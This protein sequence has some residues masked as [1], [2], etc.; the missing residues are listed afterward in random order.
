MS[1][2]GEPSSTRRVT[3]ASSRALSDDAASAGGESVATTRRG[4]TRR[5]ATPAKES[6]GKVPKVTNKPSHAYGAEGKKAYAQQMSATYALNEATNPITSAVHGADAPQL[7]GASDADR[8]PILAEEGE[9]STHVINPRNP[10][11][12]SVEDV[13]VVE[14]TSRF[15]AFGNFFE[16]MTLWAP[17]VFRFGQQNTEVNIDVDA[18]DFWQQ[19]AEEENRRREEAETRAKTTRMCL[20]TLK[21]LV[22]LALCAILADLYVGPLFGPKYDF[23]RNR[24]QLQKR[25]GHTAVQQGNN[26]TR[27]LDK[28]EQIIQN[29]APNSRFP[30]VTIKHHINWFA[31]SNGAVVDPYLSSPVDYN[32]KGIKKHTWYSRL[33]SIGGQCEPASY[34]QGQALLPWT[35][36]GERW[37]APPSR[38]KLQLTVQIA[39]PVAPTKL[40]LEH[41]P[42]DASLRIG[43]APKE[44]ELWVEVPDEDVHA[45]VSDAIG[46]MEPHLFADSSPQQ[47]RELDQKQALPSTFVPVGRWIYNIYAHDHVQTFQITMPLQEL[48]VRATRFAVRVNSNW[49]DY[50]H[51]CIYRARLHGHDQSGL[52]EKLEEGPRMA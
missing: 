7:P 32:C 51:T 46:R 24:I 27:R 35:E 14:P 37:C 29:L 1:T 15:G 26:V 12:P 28:F 45:T 18:E 17:R 47:D 36:P 20:G 25:T 40:V 52:V 49:G 38:G 22:I 33:L 2:R 50:G 11:L 42:K 41:L 16:G 9:D 3:R 48:G 34:P 13:T 30:E 10:P 23:V 6:T 5:G 19:W 4:R 21:Y 43:D 44:L 39:R 31:A 8:L